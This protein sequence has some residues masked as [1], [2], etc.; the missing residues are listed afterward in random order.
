MAILVVIVVIRWTIKAS[1]WFFRH[2]ESGTLAFPGFYPEFAEPTRKI[3]RFLL[4][5]LGVFLA[6]PYTPIAD[7]PVFQGLTIF[8]GLL[9]SLGSSTAIA[10]IVAGTL[11]T[12]TRAFQIGDRIRI[13]DTVGDVVEKTF[14]IT[15]LRTAKNEDVA[16]PNSTAL[17]AQIVNYSVMAREGAGVIVHTTVT[18]GYDVPWRRVHDLLVEAAR[19]TEGVEPAPPPFVL[20]TGLGDFSVAYQLNAYTRRAGQIAGLTSALHAAI[21]DVFAEAGIEILSPVYEARRDGST[22]T[23]PNGG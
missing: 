7:S 12:Y 9:F 14:L 22:S 10:N 16:V 3:A 17:Q 2:V 21:Q 1:N 15:R 5:L 19:R 13:G 20:Q 11:L 8:L 18:I 23:V 4:I 6:Y